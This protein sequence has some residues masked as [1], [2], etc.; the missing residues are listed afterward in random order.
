LPFGRPATDNRG[1]I[2]R[3]AVGAASGVVLWTATE[4]SVHRWVMHGRRGSNPWSADHLDHHANPDRTLPTTLDRSLWW[5]AAGLVA[6]ALPGAVLAGPAAGVA[7]GAGFSAGYVGY[8]E[9]HHRIHHRAPRNRLTRAIWH[10]HLRHHFGAPRQDYGVTTALWDRAGSTAGTEGRLLVP[11]RLA[12]SWMTDIG[13]EVLPDHA[14]DYELV[15]GPRR[16]LDHG[17]RL[18]ALDE[19]VPTTA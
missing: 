17:D 1:V 2:M 12:P 14:D 9:L 8:T 7:A 5:R 19:Q 3:I 6:V 13:G 15:G 11:R 10:R 4:Y 16:I 18:R